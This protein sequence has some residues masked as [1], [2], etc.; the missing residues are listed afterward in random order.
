[1]KTKPA[2]LQEF[3]ILPACRLTLKFL[4]ESGDTPSCIKVQAGTELERLRLLR[5]SNT[6]AMGLVSAAAPQIIGILTQIAERLQCITFLNYFDKEGMEDYDVG[7]GDLRDP[8][9]NERPSGNRNTKE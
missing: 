5:W 4:R 7:D 9:I 8:T 6:G 3:A 2:Y 1:M